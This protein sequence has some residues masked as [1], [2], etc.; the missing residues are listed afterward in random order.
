MIQLTKPQENLLK[1]LL[2]DSDWISLLEAIEKERE[3]KPWKPGPEDDEEKKRAKWI[4]ESGIL[5]G[6]SDTLTT[7]RLGKI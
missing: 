1:D 4:Y 2:R 3:L 6:I 7:L 5:R